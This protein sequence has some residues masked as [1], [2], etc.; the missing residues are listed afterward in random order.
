MDSTSD[1]LTLAFAPSVLYLLYQM[2]SIR[3]FLGA[4]G[5]RIE[6]GIKVLRRLHHLPRRRRWFLDQLFTS[7]IMNVHVVLLV[8]LFVGMILSLQM[9]I[10][11]NL[12]TYVPG[13]ESV[14]TVDEQGNSTPN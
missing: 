13:F 7:G 10:E 12:K 2:R 5:F 11:Q 1:I 6:L 9:G 4:A 8:G 3:K 14:E